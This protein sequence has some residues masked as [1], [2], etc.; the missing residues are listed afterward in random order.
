MTLY[1]CG[2]H[3][4]LKLPTGSVTHVS[5]VGGSMSGIVVLLVVIIG[6]A[7]YFLP[8]IIAANRKKTNTVSIFV[9]NLFLGWSLV[10]WVV[11]LV[12]ALAQD[13]VVRTA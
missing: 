2:Y 12:W 4:I 3:V 8:T 13:Q 7:L 5:E 9:L 10:G 6:L 11:S 1:C